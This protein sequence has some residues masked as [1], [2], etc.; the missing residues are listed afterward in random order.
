MNVLLKFK[1]FEEHIMRILSNKKHDEID[2]LIE[3]DLDVNLLSKFEKEIKNLGWI[4]N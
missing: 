4:L 2:I 1:L 3:L